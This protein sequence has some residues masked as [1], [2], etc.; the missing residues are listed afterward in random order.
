MDK[1]EFRAQVYENWRHPERNDGNP[2]DGCYLR[3]NNLHLEARP[4][5]GGFNFNADIM[6][7]NETPGFGSTN[8]E[9]ANKERQR[10]FRDTPKEA[11]EN[12]EKPAPE[13]LPDSIDATIQ[14]P[15]NP[16]PQFDSDRYGQS[17]IQNWNALDSLLNHLFSD[18][19]GALE[20]SI[21]ETYYTNNIKCPKVGPDTESEIRDKSIDYS[22]CNSDGK[23]N[24]RSYLEQEILE[25]VC[26]DV[27]IAGGEEAIDSVASVLGITNEISEDGDLKNIIDL[28]D[29]DSGGSND[30]DLRYA[31]FGSDIK[32]IPCWQF[33]TGL[34]NSHFICKRWAPNREFETG[35]KYEFFFDHMAKRIVHETSNAL[36]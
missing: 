21:S 5:F 30:H 9:Y 13:D 8:D 10:V 26:P 14:T 7:V 3:D 25:H 16:D 11:F 4:Q 35:E 12:G 24:C 6:L 31:T 36:Y 23:D 32:L 22:C 17:F 2:C 29:H 28:I 27:I 34:K 19:G 15:E 33:S 20:V 18:G 1:S